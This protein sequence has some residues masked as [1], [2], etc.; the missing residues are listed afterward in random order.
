MSTE[1]CYVR[2]TD[3]GERRR[4]R[5]TGKEGREGEGKRCKGEE[6]GKEKKEGRREG[7]RKERGVQ[8]KKEGR[9]KQSASVIFQ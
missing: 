2:E 9:K 4:R 5:G 3:L 7:R 1:S 8:G 6:G